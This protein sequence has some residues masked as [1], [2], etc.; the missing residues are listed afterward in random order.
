MLVKNLYTLSVVVYIDLCC[1]CVV[2]ISL[3]FSWW[4]QSWTWYCVYCGSGN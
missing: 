2:C 4:C 3:D 1:D